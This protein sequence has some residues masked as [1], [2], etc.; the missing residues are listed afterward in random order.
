VV[1]GGARGA[2]VYGEPDLLSTAVRNLVDNAVRYSA[3]G[4]RVGVGVRERDGL[5]EIAVADQGIGIAD[6]EIDR[7]FEP[8]RRHRPRPEHRQAHRGQPRR[9]RQGVEPGRERLDVHAA[10][11][12]R[13]DPKPH[14]R[15]VTV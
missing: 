7:V 11:A 13:A 6:D 1:V 4:T 10:A 3:D 2:K 12:Q 15:R 8:D 9:R 14:A 5:V